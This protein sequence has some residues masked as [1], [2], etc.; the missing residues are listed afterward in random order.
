MCSDTERLE[1]LTILHICFFLMW[2]DGADMSLG[3]SE[4]V[5]LYN[6]SRKMYRDVSG[7]N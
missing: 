3:D 5:L 4:T 2:Y 6:Q 7:K 1:M